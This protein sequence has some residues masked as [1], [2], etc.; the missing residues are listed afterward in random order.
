[1]G[2]SLLGAGAS[3]SAKAVFKT[4][5]K[6]STALHTLYSPEGNME[7]EKVVP[8]AA[9]VKTRLGKGAVED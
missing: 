7:I 4:I 9:R 3:L 8:V 2:L 1:M 5:K 6:I